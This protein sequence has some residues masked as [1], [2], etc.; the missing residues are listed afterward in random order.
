MDTAQRRSAR[1]PNFRWSVCDQVI[2]V[3]SHSAAEPFGYPGSAAGA[4]HG[5]NAVCLPESVGILPSAGSNR[6]SGSS[7]RRGSPR[8]CR[9]EDLIEDVPVRFVIDDDA[10]TLIESIADFFERRGDARSIADASTGSGAADRQ[11]WNALCELGVPVLRLPEPDGLGMGLLEASAVAERFGAVLLP[12]PA[13]AALVLAPVW[14]AHPAG[15]KKLDDLCTGSLI[16]TLSV[17]DSATVSPAGEVTGRI[18][19]VDGGSGD[20][21]ALLARDEYTRGEVLVILDRSELDRSGNGLPLDPTRPVAG[22][23]LAGAE[24]LDILRLTPGQANRIRHEVAVL[25]AA[26]LVGSMQQ[27]LDETVEFVTNRTQFGRPI[28]SFQAVKHQLADVYAMTE[29]ARALVRHAAIAVDDG[30]ADAAE[31]VGSVARW[32][33]RSAIAACETAVHL[34]GAMGFSWEVDVHLHLRRALVA[35]SE[36]ARFEPATNPGQLAQAG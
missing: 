4:L 21:V 32:V 6:L 3:G 2:N 14:A 5:E 18:R 25:S 10:R 33:P 24:P 29:Q 19:I 26:E 28:G 8:E 30:A 13:T 22:A 12:E 17:F 15:A 1:K 23:D 11:R 16:T 31:L 36:L 20:T 7:G 27:V 35:R 9:T 34:H